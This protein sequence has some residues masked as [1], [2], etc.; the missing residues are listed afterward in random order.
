MRGSWLWEA[1]EFPEVSDRNEASEK[2]RPWHRTGQRI[3]LTYLAGVLV[4][5][6]IVDPKTVPPIPSVLIFLKAPS[7]TLNGLKMESG[8]EQLGG[9]SKCLEET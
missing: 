4:T 8:T 7:A 3:P 5:P 9:I 1:E 2:P 6:A